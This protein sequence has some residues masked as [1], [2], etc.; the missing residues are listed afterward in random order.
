[1]KS[2]AEDSNEGVRE[3]WKD[4]K[5]PCIVL[6]SMDHRMEIAVAFGIFLFLLNNS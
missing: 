5:I 1:M 2:L 6:P 3:K 4:Y